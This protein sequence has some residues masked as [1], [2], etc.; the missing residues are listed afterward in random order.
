MAQWIRYIYFGFLPSILN[1]SVLTTVAV[2]RHRKE[3]EYHVYPIRRQ[4]YTT[5]TVWYV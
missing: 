5:R 1:I 2:L 4:S 3:E